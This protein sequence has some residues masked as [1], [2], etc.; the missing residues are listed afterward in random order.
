MQE[1]DE[2]RGKAILALVRGRVQGVGF[3][4]EARSIARSLRISG[5]I[6]NLPDGGVETYAEGSESAINRYVS[7]LNHGPPGAR[8]ESLD[9]SERSPKGAYVTFTVE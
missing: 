5:W 3:R 7:W 2:E 6:S 4:Y 9:I 8:V 1:R